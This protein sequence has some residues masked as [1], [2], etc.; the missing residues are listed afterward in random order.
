[1]FEFDE[2]GNLIPGSMQGIGMSQA[3]FGM[4]Q[5]PNAVPPI[6]GVTIPQISTPMSPNMMP[7]TTP[8]QP[9][10]LANLAKKAG[11]LTPEQAKAIA[12]MT[13]PGQKMPNAPSAGV[14]APRG[15][16]G[17]MQQQS[18]AAPVQRKTLAQLL[19]R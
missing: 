2:F 13:G 9:G 5:D 4:S 14:V 19:Y 18:M 16:Q 1:M 6:P 12:A 11:N 15:L 3:G 17:N 7:V 10:M 8:E